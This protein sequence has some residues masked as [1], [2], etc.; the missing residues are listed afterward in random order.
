MCVILRVGICVCHSS[1]STIE[2]PRRYEVFIYI[3]Y[4]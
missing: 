4:L 3:V 2:D 1:V